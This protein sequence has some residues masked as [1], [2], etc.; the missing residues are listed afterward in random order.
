MNI[1]RNRLDSAMLKLILLSFICVLMFS[2]FNMIEYST[3]YSDF[4]V[5][6][7]KVTFPY[8]PGYYCKQWECSAT[9]ISQTS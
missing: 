5:F 2:F 3:E 9:V 7:A 4:P 6:K 1:S 8:L